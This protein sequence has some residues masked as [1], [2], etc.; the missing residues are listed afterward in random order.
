[1][2]GLE[3]TL[4]VRQ[5]A[6]ADLRKADTAAGAFE[7]ALTEVAFEGLN[8]RGDRRLS[9]EQSFGGAAKAVLVCNLDE[10]FELSKIHGEFTS[11]RSRLS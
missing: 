3:H 2:Q 4:C 11:D 6:G 9:K 8:A 7:E 10:G 1:V 5:E